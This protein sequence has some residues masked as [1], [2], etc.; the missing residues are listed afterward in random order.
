MLIDQLP[1]LTDPVDSD[2]IPIERGTTSYKVTKANLLKGNILYFTDQAV[3]AMSS[4]GQLMRIPASGTNSLITINTV[5]LEC[6]FAK[7]ANI[8]SD[9]TWASYNGY[10]TFT[11]TSSAATTANVTLG[12]KGN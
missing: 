6:T 4:S 10:I 7:P 3:S 5:V 12:T 8:I 1:A 11:G 2:E 9:I